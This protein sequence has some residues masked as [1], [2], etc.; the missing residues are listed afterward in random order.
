VNANLVHMISMSFGGAEIGL[1][2]ARLPAIFQQANAQG[3]TLFA[4]SGDSGAAT[5]PDAGSF[6]RFGPAVS[7]PASYPEVTAVGGTQFNEGTGAYWAA[8]NGSD[9]S[10]AAFLHSRDC[11]E[12]AGGGGPAPFSPSPTAGGS[13][14]PSGSGQRFSG[15]FRWPRLVHDAFVIVYQGATINGILR[16]IGIRAPMAGVVALLNHSLV[17][18]GQLSRPGLGN[19][20]PQ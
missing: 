20:N 13:R 4:S 8:T 17:S 9:S 1:I 18:A 6:S 7:W 15:H 19:I 11:V 3:I 10:S 14:R 2:R 12:A 5:Y 16:H